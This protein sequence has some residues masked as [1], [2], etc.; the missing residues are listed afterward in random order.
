[1]PLKQNILQNLIKKLTMKTAESLRTYSCITCSVIVSHGPSINDVELHGHL[2]LKPSSCN[3]FYFE[4]S[5]MILKK[6]PTLDLAGFQIGAYWYVFVN[7][8]TPSLIISEVKK[9][10]Q[11][12]QIWWF[13]ENFVTFSI[14]ELYYMEFYLTPDALKIKVNTVVYY[15]CVYFDFLIT[16]VHYYCV[17]FDFLMH[18][19]LLCC[20]LGDLHLPIW[21]DVVYGWLLT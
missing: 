12:F 13:F 19:T 11:K 4:K 9:I 10:R 15:Y 6:E 8:A 16:V 5:P 17:Y 1:M 20:L 21:D 3:S 14:Y 2:I 18:Q 7:L